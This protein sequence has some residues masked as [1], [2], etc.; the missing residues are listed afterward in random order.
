MCACAAMDD[1]NE[2]VSF[3]EVQSTY[4]CPVCRSTPCAFVVQRLADFLEDPRHPRPDHARRQV[5]PRGALEELAYN[6]HGRPSPSGGGS[7]V[8]TI[9][10][11][12]TVHECGRCGQVNCP[13]LMALLDR[14]LADPETAEQIYRPPEGIGRRQ[15]REIADHAHD[16][17]EGRGGG[18][19]PTERERVALPT[20]APWRVES[21]RS[22]FGSSRLEELAEKVNEP[23]EKRRLMALMKA[24]GDVD[25]AAALLESE[26]EARARNSRRTAQNTGRRGFASAWPSYFEWRRRRSR[27]TLGH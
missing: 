3:V 4:E 26:G 25:T 5:I 15:L 10:E 19:A 7:G 8:L 14:L 27:E 12:R 2:L 17:A 22:E 11:I 21:L 20:Y 13:V 24:N 9:D 6:A 1:R 23:D 18:G 16:I